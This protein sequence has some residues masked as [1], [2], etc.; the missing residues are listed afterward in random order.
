[1]IATILMA[2][3]LAGAEPPETSNAPRSRS[4]SAPAG[5]DYAGWPTLT[6]EPIRVLSRAFV[7]CAPPMEAHN[8]HT[9]N[10]DGAIKVF[11][12]PAAHAHLMAKRAG[13][14]PVG[15]AVVKEKLAGPKADRLVAYAAMIKRD[16]GYDPKHGDWEYVFADLGDRGK[17]QR[18]RLANC[19]ACHSGAASRDYLFRPYLKAEPPTKPNAPPDRGEAA[20][21]GVDYAGWPSLTPEP[22]R[23]LDRAFIMCDYAAAPRKHDP[24]IADPEGAIKVFANPAAHAH[25]MAKRAGAL[26]VGAAVVKEKLAGPKA[27]RLVAYAAMIKRDAGYDPKHGDWE[28]VFADL[29]DRGKVQRGRLANCIACHSGAASRDYLFRPYLKA[30][31]PKR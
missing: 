7:M 3:S 17:V 2:Q 13:A 25:L 15:A 26:P 30:E 4:E 22:I 10:L 16:A 12:N 31:P 21:A 27:D 11:A 24:H 28:Y 19:I 6:P 1:M 18:G 5:V 8:P 29:G 9:A 23:M 20:P 14:L